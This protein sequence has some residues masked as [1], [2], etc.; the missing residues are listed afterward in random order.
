M[1]I[2]LSLILV[3][4]ISLPIAN[5]AESSSL[6]NELVN[7]ALSRTNASVTYDGAY[8]KIAYPM[9]DVPADVGVCTDVVIR[10]YRAI[11]L[12]LQELV[13][14]DMSQN[15]SE[16]PKNWGLN[17]P[18]TN[19]DH[20]RVPNLEAFFK[21]YAEVLVITDDSEDYQPGDIVSW[22]LDNNLPHIGIV[23]NV[24]DSNSGNYKIVHNIGRG[25]TLED[26]L[27]DYKIVGHFGYLPEKAED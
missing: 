15:F 9:G 13:H 6:S 7:A 8:R 27:F 23:S 5:S 1:K 11:D 25:P 24:K 17:R 14:I 10:A 19:I 16:Y 20:R 3:L 22:R 18:D 21:R 12:D 4:F 2:I 26:M